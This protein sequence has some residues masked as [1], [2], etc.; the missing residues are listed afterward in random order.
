MRTPGFSATTL[1]VRYWCPWR[2]SFPPRNMPVNTVAANR[3]MDRFADHTQVWL[4]GYGSLIYKV[5]FP[6]IERRPASIRHW[7]RRFWQGSHDHRGT[8]QAPGR[9]VTL[10]PEP[11]AVCVG[12]AY[13]I[14]PT[15]FAQL[16]ARTHQCRCQ[17][18]AGAGLIDP[19]CFAFGEPG[20]NRRMGRASQL[21][22]ITVMAGEPVKAQ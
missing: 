12:M 9:V 4:F 16:D 2:L 5:D 11:D 14:E 1:R 21:C 3:R 8:P 19:E 17:S 15:V 20:T 10:V 13:L 6:Y 7:A 18:G 22:R